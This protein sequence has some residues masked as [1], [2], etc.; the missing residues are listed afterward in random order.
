MNTQEKIEFVFILLLFWI[1]VVFCYC[2]ATVF[3]LS[4]RR[5]GRAWRGKKVVRPSGA[6]APTPMPVA[7]PAKKKWI[8]CFRV[9]T[10]VKWV[11]VGVAE[12]EGETVRMWDRVREWEWVSLVRV[13]LKTQSISRGK[14]GNI[15]HIYDI[16]AVRFDLVDFQF[17]EL[18]TEP[19]WSV[20]FGKRLKKKTKF[21]NFKSI[22]IFF[23]S[24]LR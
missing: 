18:K 12:S 24:V 1:C 11:R 15:W 2:Y 19:N 4:W 10:R 23:Y 7:Q 13:F 17:L 16:H 14:Y 22:F 3:C 9:D 21:F 8:C 6:P 5:R 20:F